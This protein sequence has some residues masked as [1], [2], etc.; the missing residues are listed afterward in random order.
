MKRSGNVRFYRDCSAAGV[1]IGKLTMQ[2]WHPRDWLNVAGWW[3]S[4]KKDRWYL[5]IGFV[6][7][8]WHC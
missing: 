1:Q 3:R 4:P 2:F 8:S 5:D 6:W 7:I